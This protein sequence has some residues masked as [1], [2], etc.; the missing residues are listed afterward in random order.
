MTESANN[1]PLFGL[2]NA[3]KTL[4]IS[5]KSW[6]ITAFIGQWAFAF[7]LLMVY[8]LTFANALDVRDF[9]PAPSVRSDDGAVFMT[10]FVHVVPAIYL[11]LFGLL[12]LVSKLR[13]C[14][15]SFHRWNGRIF[16]LLGFT[17]ALTGL[18]LQWSKGLETNTA[19]SLGITL[20]GLLIL[21]ATYFTWHYA[22]E[23]RFDLHQRWAIH[24]FFLVNGVWTFRLY[25]MAWYMIN[26]GP[27]GNTAN[28]DGPMDILL[29]FACYLLPMALTELYFW[30]KKQK[31][32]KTVWS[33]AM[34]CWCG[35]LFTAI[36][37]LAAASMMW[38]P[39]ISNVLNAI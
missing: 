18:F 33:S 15:R 24:T 27:N 36:G 29:S 30:S 14:Y 4:D 11:S 22:R 3:H 21:L 17:G 7:Y 31:V 26:Q 39:R 34:I 6:F 13:N 23:K 10:F 16:L 20:N 38:A 19:A 37:V 35:V 12:Q 2:T 1:P 25:L 28:I 9:S 5:V 32:S 8:A